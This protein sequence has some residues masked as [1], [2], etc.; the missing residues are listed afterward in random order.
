MKPSISLFGV[1]AMLVL[2]TFAWSNSLGGSPT[3]PSVR[4]FSYGLGDQ[5]QTLVFRVGG[6]GGSDRRRGDRPRL[7]AS[8]TSD[9]SHA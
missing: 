4:V 1:G 5:A 2:P 9:P 6:G 3:E 7:A 8:A